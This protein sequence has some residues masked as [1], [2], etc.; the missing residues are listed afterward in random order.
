MHVISPSQVEWPTQIVL[1]P[2]KYGSLHFW[3]YFR[4]RNAITVR[5]SYPIPRLEECIDSL[6]HA[7]VFSTLDANPRYWQIKVSEG[8]RNKTIFT[9][10]REKFSFICIP[11]GLKNDLATFRRVMD[12]ILAALKWQFPFVYLNNSIHF[13][14]STWKHVQRIR[15]ELQLLSDARGTLILKKCSFFTDT[16]GN[17]RHIIRPGKIKIETHTSNCI[18]HLKDPRNVTKLPSFLGFCNAFRQFIPSFAHI[19]DPPNKSLLRVSHKRLTVFPTK[20]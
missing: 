1:I 5:D 2:R 9:S 18:W 17:L 20:R 4:E 11:F 19:I 16:L 8:I 7:W 15:Q 12:A 13:S 3:V 10:H 6:G 14:K